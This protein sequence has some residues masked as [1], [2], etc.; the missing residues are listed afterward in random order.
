MTGFAWRVLSLGRFAVFLKSLPKEYFV[1]DKAQ[2]DGSATKQ[3][4][5][6]SSMIILASRLRTVR[7]QATMFFGILMRIGITHCRAY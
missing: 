5:R 7:T 4:K 6:E 3:K 2:I 1:Y